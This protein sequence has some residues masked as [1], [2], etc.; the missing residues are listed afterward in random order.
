M[1]SPAP[2]TSFEEMIDVFDDRPL[3]G[4][5]FAEA[6]IRFFRRYA[7]FSGRASRSELWWVM[8]FQ[9]LVG[10]LWSA[11]LLF[12]VLAGGTAETGSSPLG[13]GSTWADVGIAVVL[14]LVGVYTL[15]TFVPSVALRTRR[16]HDAGL[17]GW[18]QLLSL[19]PY[20]ELAV[21]VLM[22]LPSNPSGRRFDRALPSNW[23]EAEA[24]RA[25][26]S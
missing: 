8:L 23:D 18:F 19:I 14:I 20:V 10:L 21:L 3:P 25:T 22:L 15:A 13:T 16:L 12:A 4:A 26:R 2:F 5:S 17:S 11:L 24:D 9:S 7:V 6:V 1:T